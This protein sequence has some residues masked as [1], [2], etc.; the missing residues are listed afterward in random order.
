MPET[1]TTQ[2]RWP[3]SITIGTPGK[4]GEIKV[5]FNSSDLSESQTRID[6]SVQLRQH[7]LTRLSEG[8]ARV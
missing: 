3:D 4:G 1:V 2:Q 6:N 8:G 7:L 5:Y